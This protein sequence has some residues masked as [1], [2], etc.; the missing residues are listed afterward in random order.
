MKKLIII[1]LLIPSICFSQSG[2]NW[3]NTDSSI[4][5]SKFGGS[6]EVV[7]VFLRP[8]YLSEPTRNTSSLLKMMVIDTTTTPYRVY[9][10]DIGGAP[11][12]SSWGLNGNAGTTPGTDF[13]GTSD[14]EDLHIKTDGDDA[15]VISAD[16][17]NIDIGDGTTPYGKLLRFTYKLNGGATWGEAGVDLYNREFGTHAVLNAF[18]GYFRV[19]DETGAFIPLMN[20]GFIN[21]A[22][23]TTFKPITGGFATSVGSKMGLGTSTLGGVLSIA[24]GTATAGTAPLKLTTG[25]VNTSAEVGA[26]EYTTPQLFFTNGA[27]VRQEIPQIQQTRVSTQFDKTNTTLANVTGLTANLASGK[28]YRFEAHLYT[29]SDVAGGVKVAIAGT[30]TATSI[31]YEGLTTNAGLITQSRGTALAATVGAVTAVTA[32]YIVITGTVTTDGAGTLTVQFAENAATATSS[33][34]AGSTFVVTEIL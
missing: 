16:G 33:V 20:D 30:C 26:M 22:D 11:G 12:G 34:L 25:T 17:F 18:N 5:A 21:P 9:W 7:P 8:L 19:N 14:A 4:I 13:I 28:T 32:A 3:R 1:L 29:T 2:V 31:I 15:I 27:G 10:Q 6:N 24:A 23:G